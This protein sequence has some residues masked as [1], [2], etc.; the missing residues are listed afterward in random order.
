MEDRAE[1]QLFNGG[2]GGTNYGLD[3]PVGGVLDGRWVGDAW[4]EDNFP[5]EVAEGDPRWGQKR[6]KPLPGEVPS[7][8]GPTQEDID[9]FYGDNFPGWTEDGTPPRLGCGLNPQFN[10][11]AVTKVLAGGKGQSFVKVE[12]CS[13]T[14][15][16]TFRVRGSAALSFEPRSNVPSRRAHFATRPSA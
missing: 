14:H 13:V 11:F 6:I 15:P 3:Q 2:T 10:M 16:G 5:G 12:L 7:N 1:D 9:N 8:D 4:Q